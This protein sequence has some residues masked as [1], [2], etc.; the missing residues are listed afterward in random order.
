M[1]NE[2]DFKCLESEIAIIDQNAFSNSITLTLADYKF[3]NL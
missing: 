1:T 3:L 2:R